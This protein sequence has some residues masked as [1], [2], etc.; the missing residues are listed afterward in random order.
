[1]N[2]PGP[3]ADQPGHTTAPAE[4]AQPGTGVKQR[5]RMRLDAQVELLDTI[6]LQQQP[7][8]DHRYIPSMHR[9]A[10]RWTDWWICSGPRSMISRPVAVVETPAR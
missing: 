8:R 5:V 10:L 3:S 7:P 9:D 1:M 6:D 4:S 2:V